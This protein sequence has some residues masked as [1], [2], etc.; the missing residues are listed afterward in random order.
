MST[1]PN[2]DELLTLARES[3]E[4]SQWSQAVQY[5]R[6]ND[7]VLCDVSS[8]LIRVQIVEAG[9]AVSLM[10]ELQID[11]LDWQCDCSCSDDPCIH[12]VAALIALKN[13]LNIKTIEQSQVARLVYELE[14]KNG[15][16]VVQRLLE[17]GTTRTPFTRKLLEYAGGNQSGRVAG[18]AVVPSKEDFR[19]EGI[20]GPDGTFTAG[21]AVKVLEILERLPVVEYAGTQA[22]IATT[23]VR[24]QLEVVGEGEGVRVRAVESSGNRQLA[25]VEIDNDSCITPRTEGL[26]S[27]GLRSACTLNGKLFENEELVEFIE[28]LRANLEQYFD[29]VFHVKLPTIVREDPY[30]VFRTEQE[31]ES[32]L[33]TP[34]VVYGRPPLLELG[35]VVHHLHNR[36][37][38]VA[39][40]ATKEHRLLKRLRQEL[41]LKPGVLISTFGEE[42]VVFAKKIRKWQSEE[43]VTHD[44][45]SLGRLTPQVS[46][47]VDGA[48]VEFSLQEGEGRK[49]AKHASA[50]R[51]FA[52]WQDG[53]RLVPLLEGGWAEIPNEWMSRYGETIREI[54]LLKDADLAKR[55]TISEKFYPLLIEAAESLEIEPS[56]ELL[57][58]KRNLSLVDVSVDRGPP[59]DV[60]AELRSYQTEGVQWL[61]TLKE[62]GAG[63][64]LA[65]DM[66]L[67]KTLQ[68]ICI[69]ESRS[70]VV[71]PTSVIDSWCEQ[72]RKFRPNLSVCRYHGSDREFSND[73]DV[74]VTSYGLLRGEA[75]RFSE[76]W[77]VCVLDETQNIK[78]PDSA[79]AKAAC[80]LSARFRL[81]LSGTPIENKLDDLWSQYRYCFPELLG[82]RAQF[83]KKFAQGIRRGNSR[84]EDQLKRRIRPFLLR[85]VKADVLKEL[86][87]KTEIVLRCTLSD[88][89]RQLYQ[90]I[91]LS[92]QEVIQKALSD[93]AEM[94][95]VLEVLLRLRQACAHVGL[96]P[97]N[98]ELRS[99]KSDL[100]IESLLESKEAGHRS[101]VFSQWTGMLD[102]LETPLSEAGLQ[103]SRLDGSTKNRKELIEA[104]QKAD[105]PDLML[106]SLKAGGVGITLTAADHIYLYDSWWNPAVEDQAA[107]R[108]HR[109]GQSNPVF[110]YRLMA[111]NT[112]EEKILELQERKRALAHGLLGDESVGSATLTQE[113]L[114]QLLA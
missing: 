1:L 108:A 80:S 84:V 90:S 98:T 79:T 65:D 43:E 56:P 93:K 77:A 17:E 21:Q 97:G 18:T 14:E 114:Q 85:R 39:R 23:P 104:F 112:V 45:I 86:P 69:M 50:E 25:N 13:N 9:K 2:V 100:L 6:N 73:S 28:T 87:P 92:S 35:S 74:V 20:L 38:L 4:S 47:D 89:E 41:H 53:E 94:F 22:K 8:S 5:S 61:R 24:L 42:A 103:F 3:S 75:E 57:K 76:E 105:G 32:L 78:N 62:L 67:G 48:T 59:K 40:S 96:L 26:V 95:G 19:L 55:S 101:L 81:A 60:K 111:E 30:I 49:A 11:D 52:A 71:A 113:D 63:A 51:V 91:Y 107:D 44:F 7:F 72:I 110:V 46:V 15:Q 16:L 83:E 54:Q 66:G 36:D 99:T 34:L 10:L 106:L 109:I 68:A 82:S 37:I 88:H 27:E 70:L 58:L 29:L 33:V 64:I 102:L 31:G 12:T